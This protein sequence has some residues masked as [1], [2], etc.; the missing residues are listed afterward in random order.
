MPMKRIRRLF[1]EPAADPGLKEEFE[2]ETKALSLEMLSLTCL[3]GMF[4]FPLFGTLDIIVF[5]QLYP[6]FWGLRLIEVAVCAA[7]YALLKTKWVRDHPADA[8]MLLMIASCLDIV[9]MC[10]LTGGPTSVY[11]A[12]INLTILV[13]I[14]VMILDARRVLIACAVVYLFFLLPLLRGSYDASR[15]AVIISNSYFLLI[16]MALA[17][18]WTS[19][20]EPD[21]VGGLARQAEPGQGQRGSQAAGRPEIAVLRERE[22]RGPDAADLDSRADREPLYGRCRK[23][24]RRTAG[25][26]GDDLPELPEAPGHDQPDARFLPDRGGQ[27]RPPP[28]PGGSRCPLAGDD[29]HIPA[30]GRAQGAPTGLHQAR[31][32]SG[33]RYR[34]GQVR[35]DRDEPGPQRPE[36]HGK[37][38]DRAVL[39]DGRSA[40]HPGRGGYGYRHRARASSL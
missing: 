22:P 9:A 4:L 38:I 3:I 11:Y 8:G 24:V 12:G 5:P 1:G 32:R 15:T 36:V 10:W 6:V 2:R 17:V 40:R 27:G 20:Q 28:E 13:V 19:D 30:P 37:R 26:V 7:L 39:E 35:A 33:R 16:T 14:F 23:P 31:R 29:R 21:A 18:L 34:C 25:P